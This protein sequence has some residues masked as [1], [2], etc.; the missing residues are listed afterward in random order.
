MT[1]EPTDSA[2]PDEAAPATAE[3]VEAKR[4]W[5][6]KR[7][8]IVATLL[9][10][11]T[12]VATAWSGYQASLWDGIQSSSY[13]Q[14][15]AARTD[16]S[17]LRTTANQFRLADLSIFEGWA[18]AAVEGNAKVESFYEERF[19][20]EFRPAFDAWL[21]LDPFNNDDA[22]PTPFTMP[23]YVLSADAKADALEA[24]AEQVFT[25]GEDAN[26]YSDVYTLATLL[27]AVVLFFAAISE[28]FEFPVMRI[29]L[30]GMAAAGLV[31]GLI[32]TFSQPITTG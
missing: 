10:G 4:R 3:E 1:D 22:P 7:F 9:L 31:L 15:S 12:A 11:L 6:E 24:K 2:Q 18:T 20:A 23:E 25:K 21:A 14:A 13:T 8:E 5:R 16:A 28:R 17:Q 29:T 30:L 27:F 32:I 26:D 19:R